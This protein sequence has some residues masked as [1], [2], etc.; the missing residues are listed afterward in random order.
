MKAI[1]SYVTN[2]LPDLAYCE[3][4]KH[5]RLVWL[6]ATFIGHEKS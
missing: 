1:S 5:L 6:S 4:K 2:Y 3:K